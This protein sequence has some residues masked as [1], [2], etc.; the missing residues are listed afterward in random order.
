MRTLTVYAIGVLVALGLVNLLALRGLI[1]SA[2][3]VQIFSAGFVLGMLGTCLAA[4]L[5]GYRQIL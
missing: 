3:S 2:P 1:P 5:Y 4:A